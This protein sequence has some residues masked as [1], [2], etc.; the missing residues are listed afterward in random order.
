MWWITRMY[1]GITKIIL[2][3][4]TSLTVHSLLYSDWNPDGG[5]L[6]ARNMQRNNMW[7]AFPDNE[8]GFWVA[9]WAKED[10]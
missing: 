1:K 10:P 8:G 4:I 9:Y 2:I 6:V 3:C 5:M 7:W